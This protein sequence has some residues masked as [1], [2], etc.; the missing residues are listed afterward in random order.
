[1]RSV[2]GRSDSSDRP[3]F[4]PMRSFQPAH[5]LFK[6][7]LVG[8]IFLCTSCS[9]LNM[10]NSEPIVW[11]GIVEIDQDLVFSPESELIILPG[12]EVVFHRA[13]P[14]H[15]TFRGHPN[16]VG[17]EL[18]I[19]GRV[20]AVGTAESPIVFRSVDPEGGAGSWGG[21]NLV[22]SPDARFERCQF[23]QA[24]SAIHSQNSTVA[25]ENSIFENNLVGVRFH[26]S[27][28]L[29][30]S[31]LFQNNRTAIR[32]HFGA[33]VICLN[34][35]RNNDRGLFI[36]SYPLDYH[37]ENNSFLNN[38]HGNVILGEEVPDDV[39]LARNYWGT[40]DAANIAPTFYDGQRDDYIGHVRFEPFLLQP[41]G[42]SGG[43]WNQ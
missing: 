42:G 33:P 14:A 28:I 10:Q 18:I 34:T 13:V 15:D 43:V 7:L 12:T 20:S 38:L 2:T 39:E 8:Q 3:L 4:S 23:K 24:D 31:N 6:L 19:R 29:I 26:D 32:F 25:V 27:E 40:T 35:L 37:I 9:P 1:M 16:F 17:Y 22:E 5:L 30:E 11:S 21:I 41:A 36:T